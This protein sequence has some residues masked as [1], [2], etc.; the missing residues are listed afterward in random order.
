[1]LENSQIANKSNFKEN[2]WGKLKAVYL[3]DLNIISRELQRT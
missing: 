2:A 3:L 1:M